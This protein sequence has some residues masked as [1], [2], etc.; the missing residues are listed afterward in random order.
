M[1]YDEL[2]DEEL[3]EFLACVWPAIRD[4]V[5]LSLPRH[6]RWVPFRAWVTKTK[7]RTSDCL[8]RGFAWVELTALRP[9]VQL[10]VAGW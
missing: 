8:L 10:A 5:W 6:M 9:S 4:Q 3:D 1:S 7:L 2:S